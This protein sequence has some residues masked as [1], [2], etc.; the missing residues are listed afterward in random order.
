MDQHKRTS[1]IFYDHLPPPPPLF[2][3]LSLSQGDATRERELEK[4]E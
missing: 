1:T 3:L 4:E 2:S